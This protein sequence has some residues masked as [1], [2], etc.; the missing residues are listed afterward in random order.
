DVEPELRRGDGRRE[1]AR[2][3][4]DHQRVAFAVR[5]L[6]PAH[7]PIPPPACTKV[8]KSDISGPLLARTERPPVEGGPLRGLLRRT[9]ERGG[10]E[11][12]TP[13][14]TCAACTTWSA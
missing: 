2:A 12:W 8:G 5:R 9:R 1:P 10:E 11:P 14:T 13:A 6:P 4:A 7:P 3:R